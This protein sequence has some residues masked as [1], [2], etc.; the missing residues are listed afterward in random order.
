[1][2][3][4]LTLTVASAFGLAIVAPLLAGRGRAALLTA[5]IAGLLALFLVTLAQPMLSGGEVLRETT[6]WA[7]SLGVDLDFALDGLGLLF[8]LLVLGIGALVFIY[9]SSYLGAHPE[10]G[11]FGAMLALFMGSMLGLVLADN[12]LLLYVFWSLTSLTSYLLIGFDHDKAA[13]RSAALQALLITVAGELALLAGLLLLADAAGSTSLS[14]V[15]AA[16]PTVTADPRYP[17]ILGLILIGA[18]TKSAQVPFHG[19]LPGAMAAPTPVSAYL[20]SATMVKAGVFLLARLSPALSGTDAW[21][22]GLVA[23]GGTTMVMGSV[24]ALRADDLKQ[25]LAYSTVAA[26]GTI[27]LLLGLDTELGITAALVF[28]L[29]HALYKGALFLA[30]GSIDHETGTRAISRLGGVARSMPLTAVGILLASAS[31]AGLIPFLGFIGKELAYDAA[32]HVDSTAMIV[33]FAAVTASA[34]LTVAVAVTLARLS[35]G[36]ATE[37]VAHAHEAPPRLWLPP[38]ILASAGLAV[39]L[40]PALLAGPLISAAVGSVVGESTTVKLALWHGINAVLVASLLTLAVGVVLAFARP[41]YLRTT[42]FVEAG[43]R[44]GPQRW[45]SALG[46]GTVRVATG[47]TRL[48]QDG[49]LRHYIA[50]SF[51][52]AAVL[53]GAALLRAGTIPLGTWDMTIRPHEVGVAIAIVVAAFAAV[54]ARSRMEAVAALGVVGYGVAIMYLFFSA[55]DLA[56]T[57]VLIETL[58]VIIFV[59]V[60]HAL[61]RSAAFDRQRTS[62]PAMV[63]AIAAGATM[64]LLTLSAMQDRPFG[65]VSTYYIA[66][67]VPE[68]R[69]ENVVN[70]ILVDF[71]AL[72]TLGEITV[73]TLA[74]LGVYALIR[75]R[76]GSRADH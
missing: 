64:T 57:Q 12:L 38:L 6:S 70:V 68:A 73:L 62:I 21:T 75:L 52:T 59:L 14:V 24:I 66:N 20:H 71:R 42:R 17:V 43:G 30:T 76:S 58:T 1:M 37:A 19:W 28:L 54:R 40:A 49:H 33:V 29:G 65:E 32:M 55:P 11:R 63:A 27:V 51:L 2:P 23:V 10:R 53:V 48:I 44:L 50:T 3:T 22:V 46:R 61:P 13:S 56:I 41:V 47:Q 7:P 8:A 25:V 36:K 39:G 69:G 5:A 15:L 16:G 67:S 45:F 60:L 34:L 31:M 35:A 72:D 18:F 26:L 74:A 9:S 4:V